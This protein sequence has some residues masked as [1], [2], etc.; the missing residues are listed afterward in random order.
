M[1]EKIPELR[2][3]VRHKFIHRNIC[4]HI[5]QGSFFLWQ[6][7][8]EQKLRPLARATFDKKTQ[9]QDSFKFFPLSKVG[10]N[11]Q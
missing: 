9:N 7:I 3:E 2:E 8:E 5:P 11:F 4:S 6:N 10:F 1:S